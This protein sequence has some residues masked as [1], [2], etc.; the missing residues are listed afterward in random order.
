MLWRHKGIWSYSTT[1][2]PWLLY[3]HPHPET[4]HPLPTKKE[5]WWTPKLVLAFWR[6]EN[7]FYLPGT[8]PWFLSHS[9]HSLV[10]ILSQPLANKQASSCK[11]FITFMI[12]IFCEK[13]LSNCLLHQWTGG[14]DPQHWPSRSPDLT[15]LNF[16]QQ[17]Q[18]PWHASFHHILHTA[19]HTGIGR[20]RMISFAL[21][22]S[23]CL[24]K[25][26]Q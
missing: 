24:G 18:M 17:S 15:P 21:Q 22:Q 12:Y 26:Y 11:V 10:T 16:N 7:L 3:P 20:V 13:Y 23:M 1:L 6:K 2:Q 5:G 9:A 25:T 14:G 8:E 4:N 19:T